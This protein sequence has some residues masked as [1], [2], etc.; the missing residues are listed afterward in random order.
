M[1]FR[2]L[3]PTHAKFDLMELLPMLLK[4]PN[5]LQV[6]WL[7]LAI[8]SS[9]LAVEPPERR[10][11]ETEDLTLV[12]EPNLLRAEAL[13]PGDL[14]QVIAPAGPPARE[15]LMRVEQA[16]TKM[17]FQV[18]LPSA[19]KTE[20][21]SDDEATRVFD[22]L[23]D[24]DEARAAEVMSAFRDP[25]VRG[26]FPATGGYGTTRILDLLDYEEIRAHPKVLIGFSDITGLHLAIHRRTGLI[27]FH[28]PNPTWGLGSPEGQ[29][30]LSQRWFWRAIRIRPPPSPG[31]EQTERHGYVIEAPWKVNPDDLPVTDFHGFPAPRTLIPGVARGRLLGGNLSLIAALMGTPYEPDFDGAILFLEDVGEAPYRVDRMLCTLRLAG[32]LDQLKGVVLGRFTRRE[33]EDRSDGRTT[34]D[35]VLASYFAPPGAV[36]PVLA[37]FPVGHVL[38]NITLPIG[39]PCELD[40]SEQRITLLCDPVRHGPRE[41]AVPPAGQ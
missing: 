26:V 16:L 37:D 14:I 23:A 36:I 4:I 35:E 19:A 31:N 33:N 29:P 11:M 22:Y 9:A 2:H 6:V 12:G 32:K 40:A 20:V 25:S 15:A 41:N 30:E 5:S 17:G 21:T 39:C 1:C 3:N 8:Q 24:S 7:V 10:R 34:I 38:D 28:S 18:R 27:T 13:C